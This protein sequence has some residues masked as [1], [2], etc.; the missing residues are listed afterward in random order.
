MKRCIHTTTSMLVL[1]SCSSLQSATSRLKRG[2]LHDFFIVHDTHMYC[3]LFVFTHRNW[4][5][6]PRLCRYF[7]AAVHFNQLDDAE[8]GRFSISFF[9]CAWNLCIAWFFFT[10]RNWCSWPPLCRYFAA[11]VHFNQLHDAEAGKPGRPLSTPFSDRQLL[12]DFAR[13][14]R[15]KTCVYQ[16]KR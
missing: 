6:W 3:M 2:N 14:D 15:D 10:H 12:G 4:C 8:R 13:T 5:S 11:A 16:R 7:A 9:Q 1:C